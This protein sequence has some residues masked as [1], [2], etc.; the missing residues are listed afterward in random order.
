MTHP[1]ILQSGLRWQDDQGDLVP[2]WTKTPSVFIIKQIAMRHLH[3]E[4]TSVEVD[5]FAEGAFNK[6]YQI[7]SCFNAKKYLMRVA[8][9]AEPFFKTESEVA[10][11]AYVQKHTS[12]PVP[13]VITYESDAGNEL[14]FEWILMEKIEGVPLNNIWETIP[15]TSKKDL[16]VQMAEYLAELQ[17][18]QFPRIGSLY[19]AA[20]RH[21]VHAEDE[22]FEGR[23]VDGAN[24]PESQCVDNDFVVGRT[25]SPWF[26]RD[27]RIHLPADRGPFSTSYNMMMAETQIQLERVKQLSISPD[28]EHF[29]EA[30]EWL[31]KDGEKVIETCR[32]LQDLVPIFFLPAD[33]GKES[34]ILYHQDLSARNII[35]HP[36]TYRITGIVDW[37]S[38]SVYPAWALSEYP[39]FLKGIEVL[40][41][42]AVG[43][44]GIDEEALIY[45]RQDWEMVLLR[46]CFAQTMRMLCNDS[47][48][49][50]RID[51]A[52]CEEDV[53]RKK[54]FRQCLEQLELSWKRSS[55][56]VKAQEI[57]LNRI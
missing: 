27:K 28:E 23:P 2:V 14:G 52:A 56:W 29:S 50:P 26:F 16:T 17:N 48:N 44:P 18:M 22:S 30:D 25:V 9:P 7:S 54:D 39:K 5:F 49:V 6:I 33:A 40:E 34:K 20:L 12:I 21:R 10:T 11:L 24:N 15:F 45:I 1:P 37:E 46:R 32:R 35:V 41:P 42:P 31:A 51:D 4:M 8:L 19:F 13:D 3:L 57:A 55:N 43:T 36:I 47:D 53:K 38:V